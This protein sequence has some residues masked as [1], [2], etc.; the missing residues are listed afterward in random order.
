[1][2]SYY[3]YYYLLREESGL[4]FSTSFLHSPFRKSEIIFLLVSSSLAVWP[5]LTLPL[6]PLAASF[7]NAV[8]VGGRKRSECDHRFSAEVDETEGGKTEGGCQRRT[9]KQVATPKLSVRVCRFS[10]WGWFFFCVCARAC[11]APSRHISS[12][13]SKFNFSLIS[14]VCP[15]ACVCLC[16]L[17][18]NTLSSLRFFLELLLEWWE[19]K[20]CARFFFAV[21]VRS[22]GTSKNE[23]EAAKASFP[24][25]PFG[26]KKDRP[27]STNAR[28]SAYSFSIL[29]ALASFSF[30][31]RLTTPPVY[32]TTFSFSYFHL[33]SLSVVFSLSSILS[34]A[35]FISLSLPPSVILVLLLLPLIVT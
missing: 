25:F 3:Y 20:S 1:M 30:V 21:L 35:L 8:L 11:F 33:F 24:L 16:V 14:R 18:T 7:R 22:L 10:G 26:G 6:C 15:C 13:N 23:S 34:F 9:K 2:F 31:T 4:T 5:S 27:S 32:Y 29:L 17:V 12:P 28:V 19:S